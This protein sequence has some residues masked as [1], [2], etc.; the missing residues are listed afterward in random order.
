MWILDNGQPEQESNIVPPTGTSQDFVCSAPAGTYDWMQFRSD[1]TAGGEAAPYSA[2]I[3][4][5]DDLTHELYVAAQ[6]SFG[7]GGMAWIDD[8]E[9]VAPDGTVLATNGSI[10]LDSMH[11]D[12]ALYSSAYSRLWGGKSPSGARKPLVRGEAGLDHPGGPQEELD[13][14]A[15]DTEGVWLHNLIWGG[16]NPGG[17]YELYFWTSNIR[18]YDLYYHY[19]PYRDFMDGV[20]LSNGYYQDAEAEV[21]HLDLRAWGQKDVV[22]GRAHLWVQNRNHTWRN[23]VDGLIISQL[24]GQIVVP[25]MPPGTYRIEWW[26]TYTGEIID[27]GIVEGSSAGL[28]LNLPASLSDDIAVKV[29]RQEPSLGLSTKTVSRSVAKPGDILTYTIAVV[30]SGTIGATATVTDEMVIGTTYVSGSA[31]VTPASGYL[32]D[33]RG[34]QWQGELGAGETVTVTFAVQVEPGAESSVVSNVAV[35]ECGSEHVERGAST[36]VNARQVH[37]PIILKG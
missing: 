10:D 30:N 6:N 1:R 8:I 11:E 14:L 22:H 18:S 35:I 20:P 3:I 5:E 19:K 36:I 32:D 24:S 17:M 23:V 27:S 9:I 4:I 21:S 16:V 33:A 28:V 25:D 13:D 2:R 34:I 12:A 26:N 7:A 31:S 15:Q 37:L 29:S